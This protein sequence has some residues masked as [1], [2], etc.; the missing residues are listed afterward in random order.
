MDD[1]YPYFNQPVPPAFG[2]AMGSSDLGDPNDSL[3]GMGE[4]LDGNFSGPIPGLDG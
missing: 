4:F 3:L 1:A 2:M